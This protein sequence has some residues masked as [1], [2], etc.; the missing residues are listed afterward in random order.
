[1]ALPRLPRLLTMP[2]LPTP[3]RP[4]LAVAVFSLLNYFSFTGYTPRYDEQVSVRDFRLQVGFTLIALPVV[5]YF[6]ATNLVQTIGVPIVTPTQSGAFPAPDEVAGLFAQQAASTADTAVQAVTCPCTQTSVTLA[7]V[8]NWTAPE[9]SY[10]ATLR[11]FASVKTGGKWEELLSLLDDSANEE[12][13]ADFASFRTI[14]EG[15]ATDA[16]LFPLDDQFDDR[17][18]VFAS[19]LEQSLCGLAFGLA[20]PATFA[21]SS[22]VRGGIPSRVTQ[23]ENSCPSI[24][25]VDE[26]PFFVP[27]AFSYST[28]EANIVQLQASRLRSFLTASI[29]ACSALHDLREGFLRSVRD[30]GLVTAA[31]LPKDELARE[32]ER[33][34]RQAL[35]Q[36]SLPTTSFVP[37]MSPNDPL[38]PFTDAENSMVLLTSAFEDFKLLPPSNVPVGTF[39]FSSRLPFVR[40]D[41]IIGGLG[42]YYWLARIPQPGGQAFP[43]LAGQAR[44][45]A[46]VDGNSSISVIQ[47]LGTFGHSTAG[48]ETNASWAPLGDDLLSLL[49][50]CAQGRNISV[51]VHN[52]RPIVIED[53]VLSNRSSY[54]RTMSAFNFSAACTVGDAPLSSDAQPVLFRVPLVCPPVLVWLGQLRGNS[55][56]A[57]LASPARPLTRGFADLNTD[58]IDAITDAALTGDLSERAALLAELFIARGSIAFNVSAET[59]YELCAPSICSYTT[60]EPPT[61]VRIINIALA[62]YGGTASSILMILGSVVLYLSFISYQ[63]KRRRAR[64]RA[65]SEAAKVLSSEQPSMISPLSEALRVR[66]EWR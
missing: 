47:A 23:F 8:A 52:L 28:A 21:P 57:G 49:D 29:D 66:S 18:N 32:V 26:L 6:V 35:A 30:V 16:G 59:H 27:T 9:D 65:A 51:D 41:F 14:V 3:P 31:A 43:V 15:V 62:N 48:W 34:W 42:Y 33:L 10:C 20:L 4:R 24:D 45:V 39:A 50:A 12:C 56:Y 36:A 7:D 25:G 61:V 40:T 19:V 1:L 64:Q 13:M 60:I 5:G 17:V 22:N 53:Q 55:T 63:L 38:A 46:S 44:V 37:G 58:A 54:S 2:R 11:Q